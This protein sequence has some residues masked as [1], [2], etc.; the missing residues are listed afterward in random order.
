MV[1]F[2]KRQTLM[3]AAQPAEGFSTRPTFPSPGSFDG[4]GG[5]REEARKQ[6][7]KARVG[8]TSCGALHL[9]RQQ[10]V[11]LQQT[12]TETAMTV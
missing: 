8:P 7:S 10:L 9:G 2:F 6:G 5:G 1:G 3:D 4:G 12:G 11:P